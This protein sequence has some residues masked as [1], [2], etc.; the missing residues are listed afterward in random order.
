MISDRKAH[1]KASNEILI[2]LAVPGRRL[3]S[4]LSLSSLS[5][6]TVCISLCA[7]AGHYY[8][9]LYHLFMGKA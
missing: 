8:L 9:K 7:V 6:T 4:S 1:L 2:C 5:L 3:P